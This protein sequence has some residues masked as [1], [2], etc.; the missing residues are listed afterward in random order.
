MSLT[1]SQ[2]IGLIESS[3]AILRTIVARLDTESMAD[4]LYEQKTIIFALDKLKKK[5]RESS[6][7]QIKEYTE[8]AE[9]S[10]S[11]SQ[12]DDQIKAHIAI[13]LNNLDQVIARLKVTPLM[14]HR[15]H[16][17]DVKS[18]CDSLH[19]KKLSDDPNVVIDELTV[20]CQLKTNF[21]NPPVVYIGK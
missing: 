4:N 13:V 5:G 7:R 3:V 10:V 21:P 8:K 12:T 11:S 15:Y 14:D 20:D 2:V 18:A 9:S 6:S 17:N 19:V 1:D 16:L